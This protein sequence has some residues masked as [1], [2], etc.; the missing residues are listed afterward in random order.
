[1]EEEIFGIKDEAPNRKKQIANPPD[2]RAGKHQI[3][4]KENTKRELSTV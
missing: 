1:M 3:R 4:K 2:R